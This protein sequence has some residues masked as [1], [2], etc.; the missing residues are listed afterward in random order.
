MDDIC[1]RQL[2]NVYYKRCIMNLECNT[3]TKHENMR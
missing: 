3:F 1:I 2:K